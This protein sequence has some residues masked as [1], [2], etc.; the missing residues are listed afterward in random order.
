MSQVIGDSGAARQLKSMIHQSMQLVESGI[1]DM[2]RAVKTIKSGWNDDQ[3]AQVD[4][5]LNQIKRALSEAKEA[6]PAVE[7]SLEAYAE[8]LERK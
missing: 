3:A 7:K 4:D 5:I 1:N 2:E 8:F 6:A